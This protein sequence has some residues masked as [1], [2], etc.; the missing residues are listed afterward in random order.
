[1][2]G[3][4]EEAGVETQPLVLVAGIAALMPMVMAMTAVADIASCQMELS[5]A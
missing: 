1:M 3:R 5:R 4:V 2:E